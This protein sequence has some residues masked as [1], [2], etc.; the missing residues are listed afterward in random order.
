MLLIRPKYISFFKKYNPIL[1]RLAARYSK[2]YPT[3]YK[4]R[5]IK[6][7]PRPVYK[8]QKYLYKRTYITKVIKK[9]RRKILKK[10]YRY[11]YKLI[12]FLLIPL[13]K[14]QKIEVRKF[15]PHILP[16]KD[17][18][19]MIKKQY[20]IQYWTVLIHSRF[21]DWCKYVELNTKWG[22]AKK[23]FPSLDEF[24]SHFYIYVLVYFTLGDVA[25]QSVVKGYSITITTFS[26]KKT[27]SKK[28]KLKEF[29]KRLPYIKEAIKK[30]ISKFVRTKYSTFRVEYKDIYLISGELKT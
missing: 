18:E 28:M 11:R 26:A 23:K 30:Y 20:N 17:Y 29:L 15:V 4:V 27:K 2:H 22:M 3:G 24:F 13:V 7:I 9:K 25:Q 21:P 19:A 16:Y 5:I 6:Y 14:I 10:I 8:R 1:K 12:G